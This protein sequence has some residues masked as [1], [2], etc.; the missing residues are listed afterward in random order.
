MAISLKGRVKW[1]MTAPYHVQLELEAK[2]EPLR[3]PSEVVLKGRVRRVFRSDGRLGPGDR[4]AFKLWVCKPGDEPTGPAFIYCEPF[5]QATHVEAYLCGDPPDC[6]LAASE[7]TV[8][9][10]PSDEPS[11]TVRQLQEF[12]DVAVAPSKA[13]SAGKKKVWWKRM[14]SKGENLNP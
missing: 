2:S 7:F 3:I 12:V 13:Q 9:S 10:A 11:M 4:V 14:L 1:R 5:M 8:I 6:Q